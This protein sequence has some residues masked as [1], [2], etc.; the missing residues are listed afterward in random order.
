MKENR[1]DFPNPKERE[2]HKESE[3]AIAEFDE[4]IASFEAMHSL[5]EL[6]AIIDLKPEDAPKYPVR[7]S[8]KAALIPIVAKLNALEADPTIP[9]EKIQELNDKYRRLSRA[10]GI[11]N[12]NKVDHNR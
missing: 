8:A 2:V 11:I 1:G 10:V 4:L 3:S 5:E 6:H 12:R 7:E 9:A